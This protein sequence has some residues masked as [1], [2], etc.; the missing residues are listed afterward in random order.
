[1]SN[2][3]PRRIVTIG[4]ITVFGASL[5]QGCDVDVI[6]PN[7]PVVF[8][9]NFA[10]GQQN[11]QAGF[12]DYNT[13][14]ADIF[15]LDSGIKTLPTGFTGTGFKLAGHN[16]SDDLFMFLKRR[17]TGLSP[18]TRYQASLKVSF[19]SPAGTDCMGIGGAPGE[20]VY[21]HFGFAD[22]EPKQ[23]G[24][25]LNV[26]KGNQSQ[27]GANSK[28]QGNIAVKGLPCN[29]SK[30]QSKTLTSTSSSSLQFT[31]QSDGS[32]WIFT[33]TDSG[34]EGKTTLYYQSIEL[35]LK[36]L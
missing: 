21:L 8:A 30:F 19:L 32:V 20:S 14:Q 4:L 36:L 25:N 11:W 3:N 9:Y 31:T 34:Y 17:L 15:E 2:H 23:V 28:V 22:I 6:N 1:M 26:A 29:G 24:Y 5:L 13:A 27:N 18:S 7:Q 10:Q 35:E 33:G 12:A 16:R